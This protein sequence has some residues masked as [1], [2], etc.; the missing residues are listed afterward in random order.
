MAGRGGSID[1]R[2]D[3]A[4]GATPDAAIAGD[5]ED[6]DAGDVLRERAVISRRH[7]EGPRD[8]ETV[9]APAPLN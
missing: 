6:V 4:V 8:E 2:R 1:R 9:G 3:G 5:F 7:A